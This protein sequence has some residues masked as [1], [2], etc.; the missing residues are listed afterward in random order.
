MNYWLMVWEGRCRTKPLLITL[1]SIRSVTISSLSGFL[2]IFTVYWNIRRQRIFF[3]NIHV[4][5]SR[6]ITYF[7]VI[8][9]ILK[10]FTKSVWITNPVRREW[11]M[12]LPAN[13]QDTWSKTIWYLSIFSNS[14]KS[15]F[16][17]LRWSRK[18]MFKSPDPITSFKT[19]S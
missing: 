6:D 8:P 16:D 15:I 19:A 18:R 3:S 17:S 11:V 7:T 13:Y 10:L 9:S 5:W 2:N 12:N 1:Y 14:L 4:P